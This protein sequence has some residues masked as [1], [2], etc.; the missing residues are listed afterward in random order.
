MDGFGT[1][2]AHSIYVNKFKNSPV[3]EFLKPSISNFV[4]YDNFGSEL[5]KSN[6]KN[7]E[8]NRLRSRNLY[9]HFAKLTILTAI[10]TVYHEFLLR[11]GI[12]K[13]GLLW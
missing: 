13:K 1:F 12:S 9:N 6:V 10:L 7:P 4:K 5:V 8:R 11:N 3:Q 2:F